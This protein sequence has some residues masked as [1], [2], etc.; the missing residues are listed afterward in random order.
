MKEIN[1]KNDYLNVTL[2]NRGAAIKSIV[3]DGD[4]MVLSSDNLDYYETN[5]SNQGVV[6]G[7]TAGR[8]TNGEF[9][10]NGKKYS[11]NKNFKNKHNLHGNKIHLIDYEYVI[12]ESKVV[13][14]TSNDEGSYPGNI[15]IQI[16]YELIKN[17]L[18]MTIEVITDADTIIDMTNHT[19]FSLDFKKT[20]LEQELKIEANNVWLLNDDSL[21]VEKIKVDNT[22][23]DF[24]KGVLLKNNC[25]E[26]EQF[27][28]V[29]FID[30]PFELKGDKKI[31][32]YDLETKRKLIIKTNQP[33][34]VCY[35]G[36]YLADEDFL[37]KGKTPLKHQA[38]C[39]ETQNLPNDINISKEKSKSILK[40]GEEYI[41]ETSYVFQKGDRSV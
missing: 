17:E 21:P 33:Y 25:I 20:I 18:K 4:E 30:H 39:L 14:K 10:L 35:T 41:N 8:I 38:L 2:L 27:E 29:G 1:L 34:V 26:H 9:N 36:N 40:K 15:N 13:F 32:L 6:V 23:F 16:T 24:R 19:Y 5:P 31:E 7:R 22:P 28:K 12:Y 3:F 37:F 11:I